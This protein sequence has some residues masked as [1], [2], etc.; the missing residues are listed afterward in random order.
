MSLCNCVITKLCISYQEFDKTCIFWWSV[1]CPKEWR[2]D[3]GN[4]E[5]QKSGFHPNVKQT[6]CI[7]LVYQTVA[8]KATQVT[9]CRCRSSRRKTKQHYCITGHAQCSCIQTQKIAAILNISFF[10]CRSWPAQVNLEVT[11]RFFFSS[12]LS[13]SDSLHETKSDLSNLH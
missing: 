5:S 13:L 1:W 12:P 8:V 7:L 2:C 11:F 3:V 10:F 6:S 4:D 9:Q